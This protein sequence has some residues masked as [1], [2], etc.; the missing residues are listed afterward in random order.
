MTTLR[1][2]LF[3]A[4]MPAAIALTGCPELLSDLQ[5][6][7]AWERHTID[8]RFRG[9]DGVKLG[10]FGGYGGDFDLATGWEQSGVVVAYLFQPPL[11]DC[12]SPG[13]VYPATWTP[14]T[15]GK[16]GS[17]E[18]AVFVDLDGDGGLD[19]VSSCEGNVE[20]MFVHWAPADSS[21]RL[22]PNAWVTEPIPATQ[23]A[24]RWMFCEPAQ[25][26]GA[27]GVDLVAGARGASSA[28]GY[29]AAPADPRRLQDWT[30]RHLAD[31]S[32]IMSIIPTDLD[33]DGDIDIVYTDRKGD[34]RGA[35]W[36]ENP[37]GDL[38]PIWIRRFIGSADGELMFANLVDLD[39]DGVVD[40]LVATN[41]RELRRFEPTLGL[42]L[43]WTGTTIAWPDTFGTGKGVRAANLDDDP[44]LE[45][46]FSCENAGDRAGVGYLDRQEI[47]GAPVWIARRIADNA[48]GKFDLVQVADLDCDGDLDVI[49]TE[50][51]A[52]LGVIWYEN[53]G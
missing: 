46:V 1:N 21:A 42:E 33:A 19:V 38:L 16:V 51:S 27:N 9:A 35:Y 12:T 3:V 44:E 31:A 6:L 30:W 26:D 24:R 50:E 34:A 32:W 11:Y 49:T 10:N 52:N 40:L 17:V 14:V 39:A 20:T 23:G 45:I 48:G 5:T 25:I 47:A 43:P 53:P 36:L 18:D 13:P 41:R 2:V 37:A 28:I 29:L 22:D 8:E 7:T 15:I 4:I